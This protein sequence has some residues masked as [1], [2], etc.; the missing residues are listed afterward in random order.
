MVSNSSV[1]LNSGRAGDSPYNGRRSSALALKNDDHFLWHLIHC[2]KQDM[3]S[4]Y[5]EN[6]VN[7]SDGLVTTSSWIQNSPFPVFLD[8]AFAHN[9]KWVE[10]PDI[11]PLCK[12]LVIPPTGMNRDGAERF[13]L[14]AS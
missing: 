2:S 13:T 5:M 10:F 8:T 11:A 14:P 4:K 1:R 12:E 9:T 7:D 3:V 6:Q